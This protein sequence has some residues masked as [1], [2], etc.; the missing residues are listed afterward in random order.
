MRMTEVKRQKQQE[1]E[2]YGQNLEN[3]GNCLLQ[4]KYSLKAKEQI[5]S[6]LCEFGDVVR[7]REMISAGE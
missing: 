6:E 3:V 7:E 5:L 4:K 2:L 1:H